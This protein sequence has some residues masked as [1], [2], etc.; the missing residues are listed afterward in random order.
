MQL[1]D[2][3]DNRKLMLIISSKYIL[4]IFKTNYHQ[5]KKRINN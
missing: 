5:L 4:I 3:Y 2:E 1:I